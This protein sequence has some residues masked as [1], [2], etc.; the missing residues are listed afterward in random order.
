M[1]MPGS[2]SALAGSTQRTSPPTSIGSDWVGNPKADLQSGLQRKRCRG[3]H[4][5]AT[6]RDV[7]SGGHVSVLADQD[8]HFQAPGVSGI[9]SSKMLRQV[10]LAVEKGTGCG[11][12]NG[13]RF[14]RER[15]SRGKLA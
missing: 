3:F 1:P 4:E 12:Q 15:L 10:S 14:C 11:A 7:A 2:C 9:G 8:L 6:Q 5:H 13:F